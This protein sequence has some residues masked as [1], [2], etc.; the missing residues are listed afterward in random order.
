MT[1]DHQVFSGSAIPKG[2]IPLAGV[3]GGDPNSQ[4]ADEPSSR[5]L[6]GPANRLTSVHRELQAVTSISG[7]AVRSSEQLK[8]SRLVAASP[9]A[10]HSRGKVLEHSRGCSCGMVRGCKIRSRPS[11]TTT[12]HWHAIQR[13][14]SLSLTPG[15]RSGLF[16]VFTWRLA[17]RRATRSSGNTPTS[18][19]RTW[20]RSSPAPHPARSHRAGFNIR[21]RTFL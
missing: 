18:P 8:Q 14:V 1:R 12:P 19:F 6:V 21:A 17:C 20:L 9:N 11:P 2:N 15:R 16:P 4:P 3:M 10:E 13:V 7:Q 5:V